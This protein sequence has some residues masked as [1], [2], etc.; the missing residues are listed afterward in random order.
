MMLT[1]VN[2]V[3][4]IAYHVAFTGRSSIVKDAITTQILVDQMN[5]TYELP[6]SELGEFNFC[7][8]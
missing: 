3:N 7:N 5:M 4:L 8:I 6:Y 1:T 2:L